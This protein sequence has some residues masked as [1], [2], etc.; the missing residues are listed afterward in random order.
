MIGDLAAQ[1]L[2]LQLRLSSKSSSTSK[3][4]PFV[5]IGARRSVHRI[6]GV[7]TIMTSGGPRRSACGQGME[8][9]VPAELNVR[10]DPC[11]F[12]NVGQDLHREMTAIPPFPLVVH[13]VEV[14]GAFAEGGRQT[15]GCSAGDGTGSSCLPSA[16]T[17]RKSGRIR[18][19]EVVRPAR[20]AASRT[21]DGAQDLPA[22]T[23]RTGR[24]A[25]P[26]AASPQRRSLVHP[27]VDSA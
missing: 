24:M 13:Q 15:S 11:A 26:P 5:S 3:P 19:A 2:L 14:A 25:R 27:Q 17:T 9:V 21:W 16:P 4:Q 10:P 12:P 1:A 22:A 18:H 7:M 20:R 6:T 23:R 8:H